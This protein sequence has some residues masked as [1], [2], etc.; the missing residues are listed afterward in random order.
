[1][2]AQSAATRLLVFDLYWLTFALLYLCLQ[3]SEPINFLK[4]LRG[5]SFKKF[6]SSG[7]IGQFREYCHQDRL[8][9]KFFVPKA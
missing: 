2:A 8:K 4:L 1:M 7:L 5:N 6:I 3:L 9:T